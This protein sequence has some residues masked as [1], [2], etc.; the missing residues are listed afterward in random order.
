MPQLRTLHL[1]LSCRGRRRVTSSTIASLRLSQVINIMWRSRIFR[2]DVDVG[3]DLS[4]SRELELIS[5]AQ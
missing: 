4:G 1:Q 5:L 3:E 2:E